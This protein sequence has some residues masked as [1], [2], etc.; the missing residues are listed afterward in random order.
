VDRVRQSSLTDVRVRA[1]V[2][3]LS[4]GVAAAYLVATIKRILRD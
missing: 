3:G 4:L 1:A 2:G